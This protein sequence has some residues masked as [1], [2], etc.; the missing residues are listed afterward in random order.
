MNSMKIFKITQLFL[1]VTTLLSFNAHSQRYVTE[2]FTDV[3]VTNDVQYATNITVITGS[4]SLD[5]LYMDV[6]EPVGDSETERPV[7]II[8]HDGEFLPVPINGMPYGER[9]DSAIVHLCNKLA[10]RGFVAISYSYRLGWNPVASSQEI[11]TG[12]YINAQ[13]RAAQDGFTL[14]RHLRNDVDVQGNTFGIDTSRIISGG[15]G[16]GGQISASLAFLDRYEEM[17]LSKFI[18]PSTIQSY[19]DSSL[20]GN[21]YGTQQRPL[22]IANNPSYSSNIHFAFNMGGYVSDSTW[23]EAGDVPMVSF[24]LP[25]DPFAP[26]DFGAIIVQTTGDFVTN[27]SGAKGIQRRQA[28]HGNNTPFSSVSYSDV[29][30]TQADLNNSGFD[31][32]YPFITATT[33]Y[34]PWNFWDFTTWDIPHPAGGTYNDQGLLTNPGM[35]LTKSNSYLDTVVNYLCPRIV[36]ALDLVG[37]PNAS[38]DKNEEASSFQIYPNPNDGN[39]TLRLRSTSITNSIQIT[40][41]SG[42]IIDERSLKESDVQMHLTHLNPGVYFV[43]LSNDNQ[44]ITKRVVID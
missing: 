4:P 30:T 12:T 20:S 6:Y 9:K 27:C 19:V 40:D 18:N 37:C 3:S 35:S 1:I 25:F 8:A 29:Y 15:L 31:G 21:V 16:V 39:F 33:E 26:Y 38:L 14:V 2:V 7:V 44:K 41:L 28:F 42:N 13:Y 10:K 11:R 17:T 36:C 43:T 5:T 23:I 32:L 24:G 34:S 22:T